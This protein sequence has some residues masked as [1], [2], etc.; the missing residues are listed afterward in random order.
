MKKI[1]LSLFAAVLA[2]GASAQANLD[3]ES[4]SGTPL[5]ADSW[6]PFSAE[7]SV[8]Q[9][10]GVAAINGSYSM[11]VANTQFQD[12]TMSDSLGGSYV[13]QNM[14]ITPDSV[15]IACAPVMLGTDTAQVNVDLFNGGSYIGSLV[16]ELHSNNSVPGSVYTLSYDL[17]GGGIPAF[18]AISVSFYS[19][20]SPD[21][22]GSFIIVD[23]VQIFEPGTGA[24]LAEDKLAQIKAFPN[25]ANDIINFYLGEN[26]LDQIKIIDIAG[27]TVDVINVNASTETLNLDSY[28]NGVYFYQMIQGQDVVKTSKFVVSK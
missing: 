19:S 21:N 13:Y 11:L 7:D 26:D 4:W 5:L 22:A 25:P 16:T 27:R 18:D 2:F 24:G 1:Y 10:S 23:D 28:Q 20:K 17:T 14:A 12:V 6:T 9:T 15:K 3:F 8:S